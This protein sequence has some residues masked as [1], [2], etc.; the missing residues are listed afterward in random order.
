MT[1]SPP[2]KRLPERLDFCE[3]KYTVINDN[4]KLTALRY[5]QPWM[6]DLIGDNLVY[7]MFVDALKL[8][9]QRDDLIRLLSNALEVIQRSDTRVGHCCCGDSMDNHA[10][11]MD[12]GH[13]PVD[14][15]VYVAMGFEKEARELIREIHASQVC[16]PQQIPVGPTT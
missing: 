2:P 15:G 12:C 6:R 13:S 4:G 7:W 5:G 8:K 14:M 3:G 9:T 1:Q 11:P 16:L 10:N